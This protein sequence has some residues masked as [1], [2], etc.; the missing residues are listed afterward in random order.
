MNY[1]LYTQCTNSQTNYNN[2]H[3]VCETC[4]KQI[5]KNANNQPTYGYITTRLEQVIILDPKGK[6]AVNYANIMEKLNISRNDAERIFYS[7]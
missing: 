7:K 4:N 3:P 1:G 2:E 5:N 6:A